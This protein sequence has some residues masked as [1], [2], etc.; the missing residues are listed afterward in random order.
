MTPRL[1]SRRDLLRGVA[2]AGGLGPKD[3]LGITDQ[4]WIDA[5]RTQF[6]GQIVV[7][8]GLMEV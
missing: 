2:A 4:M 8:R 6:K 1:I 5:A 3:D 7:A